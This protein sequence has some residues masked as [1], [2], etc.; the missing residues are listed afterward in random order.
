MTPR[1][2]AW[3]KPPLIKWPFYI[4]G[5]DEY[6]FFFE[7]RGIEMSFNETIEFNKAKQIADEI[8]EKICATGQK[9]DLHVVG[10]PNKNC[11]CAK[12]EYG[13]TS[14]FCNSG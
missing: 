3:S 11:K 13:A 12:L 4:V 2:F 9:A 8:V 6:S 7:K 1:N 5:K 14:Y 10:K